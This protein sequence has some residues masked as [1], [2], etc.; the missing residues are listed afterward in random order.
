MRFRLGFGLCLG[1]LWFSVVRWC[2]CCVVCY[3][4]GVCGCI[5][6]VGFVC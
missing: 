5:R 2:L 6:Y 4:L 1:V 3:G